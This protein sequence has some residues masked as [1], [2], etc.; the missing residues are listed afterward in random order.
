MIGVKGNILIGFDRISGGT[1]WVLWNQRQWR[2]EDE[3]EESTLMKGWRWILEPEIH[4][5]NGKSKPLDQS[6]G[7]KEGQKVKTGTKI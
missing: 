7:S 2:V 3:W 1:D 4:N 6:L 5:P